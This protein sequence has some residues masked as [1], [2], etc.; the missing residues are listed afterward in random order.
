MRIAGDMPG[1]Q[2]KHVEV[3]VKVM[4]EGLFEKIPPS[5]QEEGNLHQKLREP[6]VLW[7]KKSVPNPWTVGP[8]LAPEG[9]DGKEGRYTSGGRPNF[10]AWRRCPPTEGPPSERN[11][12][13]AC[14]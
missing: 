5:R 1:S 12:P 14:D 6:W 9:G 13:E 2:L 8:S 7:P 11:R 3:P 4:E 10:E